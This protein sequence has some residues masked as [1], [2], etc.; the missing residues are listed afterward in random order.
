MASSGRLKPEEKG[1]IRVEVNIRGKFGN[2]MKT[3]QVVT[4]DPERPH[5]T[6]SL[7]MKIKD[8]IHIKQYKAS[9]I[10][11]G[12]CRVCHLDRG[13]SRKGHDLFINDCMMCHNTA[14][15]ASPLAAMR[16][17]PREDIEKA[18]RTGV[19]KTS[20]PGWDA[21]HGGPLAEDEIGSL[22]DYIKP[23]EKQIGK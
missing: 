11:S 4:N 5:A 19:E 13:K 23:R 1:K 7:K 12:A 3:V 17:K 21:K 2:I 15:S 9:E 16:A 6:L 8:L 22:V 18:I 10:F 14:K 20:M